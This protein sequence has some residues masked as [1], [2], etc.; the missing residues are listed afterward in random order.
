MERPMYANTVTITTNDSKTEVVLT[1]SHKY[2]AYNAVDG[3]VA[4]SEEVVS[5][6]LHGKNLC[7]TMKKSLLPCCVNGHKEQAGNL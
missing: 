1:F 4:Q 6:I 7:Y 2:P 5:S 3:S